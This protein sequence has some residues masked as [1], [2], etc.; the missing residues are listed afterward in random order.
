MHHEE[1]QGEDEEG[2]DA[3]DDEPHATGH[4]V[5]QTA[6]VWERKTGGQCEGLMH[7]TPLTDTDERYSELQLGCI[8]L[9]HRMLCHRC[10]C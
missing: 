3:A 1:Q 9:Q 5:K 7:L 4:G 10:C 8:M 6:A 2:G